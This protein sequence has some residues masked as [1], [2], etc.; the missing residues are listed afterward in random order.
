MTII[1]TI[2]GAVRG[3][4]L[5]LTEAKLPHE[6]AVDYP[7]GSP[8][9]GAP[10]GR[11]LLQRTS[12]GAQFVW[13]NAPAAY[14]PQPAIA[15]LRVGHDLTDLT[16]LSRYLTDHNEEA[17]AEVYVLAQPGRAAT[18]RLVLEAERPERGGALTTVPRHPAWLAWASPFGAWGSPL[19]DLTHEQLADLLMDNAEDLAEPALAVLVSRFRAATKIVQ[20]VSL[21]SEG[22]SGLRV[23]FEGRSSADGAPAKLP[24][25]FTARFPAYSG[26]WAAGEEPRHEA[27]FRLRVIPPKRGAESPM[28]TFRLSWV[29]AAEYELAAARALET[30]VMEVIEPPTRVYLGTPSIEHVV[31]PQ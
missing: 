10:A 7:P 6:I 3:M 19:V 20:D 4:A 16:S 17:G 29:N 26:A 5:T 23:E 21:D 2:I 15:D 24:R 28:P 22:S 1:E 9:A 31:L 8:A 30:R 11:F 13:H 18:L 25:A 14:K 27:R 12:E